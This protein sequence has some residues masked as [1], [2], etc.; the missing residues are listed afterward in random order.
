M[1]AVAP[2]V[3]SGGT[4][5]HTA[6]TPALSMSEAIAPPWT[7]WPSVRNPGRNGRRI[8]HKSE[9][10]SSICKPRT[11]KNGSASRSRKMA[12]LSC[13][14]MPYLHFHCVNLPIQA[15]EKGHLMLRQACPELDEGDERKVF[16]QLVFSSLHPPACSPIFH[17][18]LFLDYQRGISSSLMPRAFFPTNS[19]MRAFEKGWLVPARTSR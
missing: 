8:R 11:V 14:M 3:I 4:F 7:T 18:S 9:R 5:D 10:T 2:R 15:V 17:S 13:C 12:V 6:T 16:Q 1:L 19:R